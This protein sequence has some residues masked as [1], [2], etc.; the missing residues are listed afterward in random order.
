MD[1]L[2]SLRLELEATRLW[3]NLLAL[4]ACISSKDGE[5]S[6]WFNKQLEAEKNGLSVDHAAAEGISPVEHDRSLLERYPYFEKVG[7][8]VLV[9]ATAA[10]WARDNGFI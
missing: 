8:E 9:E 10:K 5:P 2:K 3:L 1:E 7:L 4:Q 6:E